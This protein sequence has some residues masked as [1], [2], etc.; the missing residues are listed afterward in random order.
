MF[1]FDQ[2]MWF[3][4]VILDGTIW[5]IGCVISAL[6]CIMAVVVLVCSSSRVLQL[7]AGLHEMGSLRWELVGCLLLAWFIV[8]ACMIRGIKSSGRVSTT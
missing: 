2:S 3:A 1:I 5:V 8:F 4:N 7:S 6:D